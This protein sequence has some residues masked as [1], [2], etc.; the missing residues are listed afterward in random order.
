M[1]IYRVNVE[2]QPH[3]PCKKGTDIT[4]KSPAKQLNGG[5]IQQPSHT[6]HK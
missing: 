2:P 3:H 1:Q 6:L 5:H 4:Y